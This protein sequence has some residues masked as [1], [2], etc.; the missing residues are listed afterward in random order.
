MRHYQG[1][2]RPDPQHFAAFC[3]ARPVAASSRTVPRTG[4]RSKPVDEMGHQPARGS[5]CTPV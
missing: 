3:D 1:L 5:C 2:S 4:P